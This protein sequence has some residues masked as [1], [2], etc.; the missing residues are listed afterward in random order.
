LQFAIVKTDI[1]KLKRV[2][3]LLLA[4]FVVVTSASGY[5]Y[6]QNKS[7]QYQNQRLIIMNDSILSENIELKNVL[8]Q[9]SPAVLKVASESFKMRRSK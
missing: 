7:Y 2:V 3:F 9:N 8:K 6:R 5:L 1:V 4:L